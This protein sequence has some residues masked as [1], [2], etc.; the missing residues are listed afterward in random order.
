MEDKKMSSQKTLNQA[1]HTFLFGF[2]SQ[3]RTKGH[4]TNA[5]DVRRAGVVLR[6]DNYAA[7]VVQF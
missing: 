1:L 4:I 3:H 5:L 6:V 2:V 7:F